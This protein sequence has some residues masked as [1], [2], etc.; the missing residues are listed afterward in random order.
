VDKRDQKQSVNRRQF[1]MSG[2][3]TG[4][5]LGLGGTVAEAATSASQKAAATKP[6]IVLFMS[7]QFRWDFVGAN[8][9]NGSTRT[10][11]LDTLAANGKNFNYAITNQPVCAP[12]RSVMLTSLYATETPVWHN[13]I[14][15][16][17]SLPT[18]AG[19]LHKAGYS[20]NRP[21]H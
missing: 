8:G 1:L 7:D 13:G 18:L 9:L 17:Q 19:E 15:M 10:P 11:N 14:G 5:A 21:K 3:A 20:T 4:A 2:V 16:D 12:A 6:N